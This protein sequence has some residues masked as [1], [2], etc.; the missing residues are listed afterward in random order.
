MSRKTL[1]RL[2]DIVDGF[3]NVMLVTARDG[4]L[5]SR[6]MVIAD[7]RPDGRIRFITRDDSGKLDELDENPNVNVT[8]QGD[9]SFLSI[10]GT[11]RLTKDPKLIDKCWKSRQERWF[12]EG[13]D[14]PH[15]MLLEVVPTYAEFWER[16]ETALSRLMPGGSEQA[17]EEHGEVDLHRKAL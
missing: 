4:E 2:S 3:D 9:G 7:H 8:A 5:R 6:P 11:A 12:T 14:D 15:V 10:S 1:E 16:N 17:D 13:K